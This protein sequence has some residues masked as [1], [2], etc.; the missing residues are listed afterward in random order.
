MSHSTH[1]AA[2]P[3]QT[4]QSLPSAS[5]HASNCIVVHAANSVKR[6]PLLR[7]PQIDPDRP[8]P[9]RPA[10]ELQI[11]SEYYQSMG[12][13][14]TIYSQRTG[15]SSK[16]TKYVP[17]TIAPIPHPYNPSQADI[18]TH[19]ESVTEYIRYPCNAP[20]MHCCYYYA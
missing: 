2:H 13:R 7:D 18:S 5:M 19:A 9:A 16:K 14:S 3:I 11:V 1:S 10:S 17:I 20:V 15:N 12:Q 8:I 6:P 4:Q